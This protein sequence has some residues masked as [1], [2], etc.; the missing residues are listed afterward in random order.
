MS[1]A[2]WLVKVI[3]PLIVSRASKTRLRPVKTDKVDAQ[4]IRSV[5]MSGQGYLFNETAEVAMLKSLVMQRSSLVSMR[6]RLKQQTEAKVWREKLLE[7]TESSNSFSRVFKAISKEIEAIEQQ[8]QEQETE[9]QELL[10]SIPGIGLVCAAALVADVGNID[11]FPSTRQFVAYLGLD[12][13]VHESGTSVHGKGYLT[14]RGNKRLRCLLFS[15]ALVSKRYVPELGEYYEKK[16]S[17]G[18]HHFSA[19]CATER[20]LT[21]IVYAVWKRR[22]PF[23]QR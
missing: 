16:K 2:G 15:A 7:N 4:I 20:K 1:Q 18:H 12:C 10:R 23:E 14:K 19:L 5:L 9:D 13:R 21:N 6:A 8:M 22:T 17:E 11:R 3:N